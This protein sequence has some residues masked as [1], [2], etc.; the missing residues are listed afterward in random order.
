MGTWIYE[1][2]FLFSVILLALYPVT[3]AQTDFLRLNP[4]NILDYLNDPDDAVGISDLKLNIVDDLKPG[5]HDQ[6][7]SNHSSR[8]SQAL[9]QEAAVK[10]GISSINTRQTSTTD[11]KSSQSC[12]PLSSDLPPP[13]L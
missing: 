8:H 4:S 9:L 5:N 3:D 13:V 6:K 2:L 11:V 10:D 12:R 7:T 1:L